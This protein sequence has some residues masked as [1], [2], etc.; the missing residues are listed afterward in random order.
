MSGE[1]LGEAIAYAKSRLGYG[2]LR[3]DQCKVIEAY[4]LGK[5]VFMC[6]KTGSGKSL[7]FE[8]APFVFDYI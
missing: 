8:M 3:E 7:T 5:D 4:S 6:A 2:D 1:K